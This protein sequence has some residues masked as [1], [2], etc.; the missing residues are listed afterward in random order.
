MLNSQN[1]RF[2]ARAVLRA[3]KNNPTSKDGALINEHIRE[4]KIVPAAITIGLLRKAM[5]Q[6]AGATFLID[7]FPRELSQVRRAP[8]P[9]ES[10]ARVTRL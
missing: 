2:L 8:Y 5:E 1:R 6:A 3:E 9:S 10:A 7:G 4:G